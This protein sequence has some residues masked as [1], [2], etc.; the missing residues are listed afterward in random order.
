MRGLFAYL[1][2]LVAALVP[3]GSRAPRALPPITYGVADNASFFADDG[4]V[5]FDSQLKAANLDENR[6]ELQWDPS[7]PAAIVQLPFLQR[8][9]PVAQAAGVHVVLVLDSM[10]PSSHDPGAFCAWAANLAS[11]ASQWGI[12]DYAIWN[13]PNT[14]RYWA[15]QN[16]AAP[17]Q[18]ER[19]LARC[20]DAIHVA[21]PA[22]RVVG[23]GLSPRSN[24]ATQTAPIP[25]ILAAGGAYKA[26]GRTLPIMDQ[27]SIHPYPNPNNPTDAPS[28]GYAD[29]NDY[30]VPNLDRVKQAVYDAFHGTAQ[31]TTLTGLTFR[32]DEF[33]WQTN[34]SQYPQ[35]YNQENVNVVSEQTQA[36]YIQQAVQTYFACDPTVTNVDWFLLVDEQT[37]NGRSRDGSTVISGGWQSGL[38]T[39]G[40]EGVSTPKLAYSQD[41]PLFAEGR[42]ACTGARVAWEPSADLSPYAEGARGIDVSYPNCGVRLAGRRGFAVVG[43][44]GGRP[45]SV[46]PCLRS[47]YERYARSAAAALYL[48]TGYESWYPRAVTAACAV[49]ARGR[50]VA[51]AVGCS[52]AAA[53]LRRLAQL[54]LPPPRVWW[55][56]V[57]PSNV[58]SRRRG[59]NTS[60][61][62]GMM[63]YLRK[64]T[65]ASTVG[66]YSMWPWWHRITTGWRTS[67]P[68]WIPGSSSSCPAPFSAGPVWLTQA[69]SARLDIDIAC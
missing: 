28:V 45:F 11:V 46:N 7:Q 42:A 6:W 15:P 1:L 55:L 36:T 59:L 25:F 65:S 43:V 63:D 47:Q 62:R 53:S 14:A 13:E 23:F 30:G 17:A 35:Y 18:Y 9:A 41:A 33:G 60:V 34:T 10:Q 4:G 52:E 3:A 32:V 44:N 22:A 29:A 67:A 20:Y 31:P 8:A 66:I 37:R 69:G 68:E 19:L 57:E 50:G 12:D 5:W 2:A 48:N 24:G 16:A 61:L 51:Y 56:D 64:S 58:W 40:G 26:S 27:M 39:A 49:A 21:D 38:M 54:R